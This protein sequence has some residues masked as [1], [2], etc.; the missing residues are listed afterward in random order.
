MRIQTFIAN[1]VVIVVYTGNEG[2][3]RTPNQKRFKFMPVNPLHKPPTRKDLVYFENSPDFCGE[4]NSIGFKGTKGRECNATSIG[5]DGCDL[6]CCGRGFK[7]ETY[8]HKERCSCTFHWCCHV[9]CDTCTR[10]RMRHTCLWVPRSHCD[11]IY[12]SPLL[13]TRFTEW[14]WY[15]VVVVWRHAGWRSRTCNRPRNL[16]KTVTSDSD[17]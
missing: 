8:I 17:M 12:C 11:V 15:V 14:L 2:S 16:H 1:Q 6:M 9:K 10:T 5:V 13:T 3:N 4:D 7:T